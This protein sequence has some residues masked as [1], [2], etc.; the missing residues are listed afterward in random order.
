MRRYKKYRYPSKKQR[1]ILS[2]L[3]KVLVEEHGFTAYSVYRA[4]R[5]HATDFIA[6]PKIVDEGTVTIVSPQALLMVRSTTR[7]QIE[8]RH[9]ADRS[10][11]ARL[12]RTLRA[13]KKFVGKLRWGRQLPKH[14]DESGWLSFIDPGVREEIIVFCHADW[15]RESTK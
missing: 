8:L 11:Y 6:V 4:Y 9:Y 15:C 14:E 7:G 1:R 3:R 12:K 2:E 10:Q 13:S 5:G